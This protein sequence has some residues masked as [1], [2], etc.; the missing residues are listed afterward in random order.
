MLSSAHMDRLQSSG[1]IMQ[2]FPLAD[3]M[4]H[5]VNDVVA[6]KVTS[7]KRSGSR[8]EHVCMV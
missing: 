3:S 6:L 1:T 4:I 7:V 2:V 8:T 5:S